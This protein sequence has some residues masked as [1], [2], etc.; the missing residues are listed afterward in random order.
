MALCHR[1][2]KLDLREIFARSIPPNTSSIAKGWTHSDSFALL[3]S[4]AE[5]CALC[6]ILIGDACNNNLVQDDDC[7]RLLTFT[8]DRWPRVDAP[9]NLPGPIAGFEVIIGPKSINQIHS[10]RHVSVWASEG[11]LSRS[12]TSGLLHGSLTTPP[13]SP[14]SL[15]QVI[16][17]RPVG[18]VSDEKIPKL[19]LDTC[20]HDH[21][22]CRIPAPAMDLAMNEEPPELPTRVIDVG[23]TDP[24]RSPAL[25]ESRGSKGRYVA[26]S[27]CWGTLPITKTEK[28]TLQSRMESIPLSKISTNFQHAIEVTRKL[29]YWYLWIDALCIIQDDPDDWNTESTKMAE[30]YSRASLT[31]AAANSSSAE[32]GFLKPRSKLRTVTVP[33]RAAAE[34]IVGHFT[35]A[36]QVPED[37]YH[38]GFRNDVEGGPLSLRGWTLQ[39]RL[40]SR[41]IIFFGKEEFHWECRSARWSES[42]RMRPIRY[43]DIS[44]GLAAFH[45]LPIFRPPAGLD[46]V[47]LLN[48]WYMVVQEFTKRSLTKKNID[49]LPALAGIAKVVQAGFGLECHTTYRAGLWSHDLPRALVWKTFA[50]DAGSGAVLAGPS[51]SWISRDARIFPARE[52][53]GAQADILGADWDVIPDG[54]D[55]HGR[56]RMGTLTLQGYIKQVTSIRPIEKASSTRQSVGPYPLSDAFIYDDQSQQIAVAVLDEPADQSVFEQKLYAV[57]IRHVMANVQAIRTI[58]AL[59]LQERGD[60]TF[61]RVGVADMMGTN[62]ND[63]RCKDAPFAQP[64]QVFF[65]NAKL[66]EIKIV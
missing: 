62:A 46:R 3:R 29:G 7:V 49:K 11:E 45:G 24:I 16:M 19:W 15:K 22:A 44:A 1:C 39:E 41:R 66:A 28:K 35:I 10:L 25:L 34:L 20:L 40:L 4:S 60:G 38:D 42:T 54:K 51:W 56:V 6:S 59:L 36:E 5:T 2:E 12:R 27:H 18:L 47:R 57:P 13:D 64:F 61:K 21:P 58:E 31:L 23:S 32:E 53:T 30:V 33:Y 48:D 26:L 37:I 9:W 50:P 55:S 8:R 14:E 43:V 52:E 65:Y 63:E 17:P